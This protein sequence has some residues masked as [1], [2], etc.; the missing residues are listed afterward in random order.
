MSSRMEKL[1]GIS[2]YI[3]NSMIIFMSDKKSL[4]RK[5]I[6]INKLKKETKY[7]IKQELIRDEITFDFFLWLYRLTDSLEYNTDDFYLLQKNDEKRLVILTGNE[8]FKYLKISLISYNIMDVEFKTS[9]DYLLL[10]DFQF[11][12]V[13]STQFNTNES[14]WS[15]DDRNKYMFLKIVFEN[16]I[17]PF[18][19]YEFPNIKSIIL[20]HFEIKRKGN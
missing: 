7:L 17:I 13:I 15:V 11:R 9:S 20:K 4:I 12:F 3:A 14:E 6:E 10:D 19:D 16:M 1:N 2:N 18:L 5:I 8:S